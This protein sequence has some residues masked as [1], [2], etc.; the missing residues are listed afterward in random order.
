MC[1]AGGFGLGLR[2]RTGISLHRIRR[3]AKFAEAHTPAGNNPLSQPRPRAPEK[4][5]FS[6]LLVSS[7]FFPPLF[8]F[9]RGPPLFYHFS[10]IALHFSH[11]D[12]SRP[13]S[14]SLFLSLPP[15]SHSASATA[16]RFFQQGGGS[17]WYFQAHPSAG[18]IP[19]DPCD[20]APSRQ[21]FRIPSCFRCT[22]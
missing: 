6:P 13:L 9:P 19:C 11:P 10:H 1:R 15:T 8:L 22:K 3:R 2:S 18:C 12:L 21:S 20:P 17:S 4:P 16:S 5:C 7:H 14:L